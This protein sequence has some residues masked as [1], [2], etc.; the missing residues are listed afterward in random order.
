MLFAPPQRP[1]VVAS[2]SV[3]EISLANVGE[4]V[5]SI[6]QQH[7]EETDQQPHVSPI[8]EPTEIAKN[9]LEIV[10]AEVLQEEYLN[11]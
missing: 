6:V 9:M 2:P 10:V 5:Q 3:M 7:F 11:K 1:R 8:V 4:V